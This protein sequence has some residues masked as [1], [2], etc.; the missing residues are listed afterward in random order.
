MRQLAERLTAMPGKE[1]AGAYLD[2]LKLT[3]A[4][5]LSVAR[6]LDISPGPSP[7]IA[8]MKANIVQH[9]IGARLETEAI[10]RGSWRPA[11]QAKF[12]LSLII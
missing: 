2:S 7:A 4:A 8:R 10:L 1:E 5:L 11:S 3:R 12:T 9:T 6:D